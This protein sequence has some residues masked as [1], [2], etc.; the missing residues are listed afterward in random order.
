MHDGPRRS[1]LQRL[2]GVLFA[3]IGVVL[4]VVALA[5]GERTYQLLA[6][7][8]ETQGT[9]VDNRISRDDDGDRI[10]YPVVNF[11]T[12]QGE[13]IEWTS[14]VGASSPRHSVG[15]EVTI[16]YHPDDPTRALIEAGIWNYGL[17]VGLAFGGVIF[18]AFGI[19]FNVVKMQTTRGVGS[20]AGGDSDGG[21]GGG[22]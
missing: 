21:D 9:V 20:D 2:M 22:D 6:E 19:L 11:Q 3:V 15:D 7:G 8:I 13:P 18:L 12:E 4:L 10:Y 1:P 16:V 17:S 14:R 5:V